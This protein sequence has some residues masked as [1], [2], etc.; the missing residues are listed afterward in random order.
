MKR[1]ISI[2]EKESLIIKIVEILSENAEEIVAAYIFGS[3]ATELL[4]SDIDIG[5]LMTNTPLSALNLELN[6]ESELERKT[7]YRVDVRVLNQAPIAFVQNVIRNGRLIVDNA[8]NF[9]AD[10]EGITLKKYFDFSRFRRRYLE[11]VKNAPV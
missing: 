9:R 11:E 8:P 5:L 1:Q 7:K 10:F 6:I 2:T 3:F 4:F